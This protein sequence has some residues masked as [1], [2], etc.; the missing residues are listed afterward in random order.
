MRWKWF[1]KNVITKKL[2]KD[3]LVVSKGPT[4]GL[5]DTTLT[6]EAEYSF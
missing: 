4:Q 1:G 2:K 3:G 6:A 5:N